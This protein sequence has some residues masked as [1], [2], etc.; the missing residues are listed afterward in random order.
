MTFLPQL[1]ALGR[2]VVAHIAEIHP[3]AAHLVSR[4]RFDDTLK[5][6]YTLKTSLE[7]EMKACHIAKLKPSKRLAS[8]AEPDVDLSRYVTLHHTF[9]I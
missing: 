8:F 1:Y 7:D 2:P 5:E 3:E 9:V 4:T 6:V